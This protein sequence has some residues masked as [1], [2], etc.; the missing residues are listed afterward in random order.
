MDNRGNFTLEIV[1]VGII[2]ILI[3]GV[4][5]AATEISQ[6][7]ISKS[8]ENNNIEKTISEV[9]DSLINDAGTPINWENFKPKRI[10]LATTNG[11]DNVIPNSVSYYKL[12]ELGKDYDNYVTKRIFDNKFYSSMELIPHETSISSVKI[13]SNEE[14]TNNIYS[15]N[16]IVKCDFFKK[17]VVCDFLSDGKCNHDHNQK[18]HSCNYLKLFKGNLKS[19]DYYL[20]FDDSEENNVKYSIDTTHFKNRGDGKI[21]SKTEIYLNNDFSKLFEGGESSSVIFIHLNKKDAKAVL[22]GVPKQF[23]KNKLNY[24]YFTTQECDFIIK[25]WS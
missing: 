5:L 21:V 8:V 12:V 23:D 24:N 22:V 3:L 6:E 15:V 2:I 19:L 16:R 13:G 7:K 10:G 17:Y 14:G 11:D 4:V 20:L 9:C 25:A 18:H 1:V